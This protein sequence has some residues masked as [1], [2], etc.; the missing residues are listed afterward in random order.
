MSL[1]KTQIR[2]KGMTCVNCER[3]IQT[4]LNSTA[5]IEKAEVSDEKGSAE[6]IFDTGK[7]SLRES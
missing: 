2:I 5:G 4:K 3:R 1:V 6:L 7:I